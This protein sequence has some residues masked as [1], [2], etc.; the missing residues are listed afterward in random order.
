MHFDGPVRPRLALSRIT[1]NSEIANFVASREAEDSVNALG[2]A[3]AVGWKRYFLLQ[4]LIAGVFALLLA[5]AVV[6]WMR[7]SRR[8]TVVVLLAS[9]LCVE[10]VNVGAVMIGARTAQDRLR[11][12]DSLAAL[13]GRTPL[14]GVPPAAEPELGAVDA[15]VLGVSV[16]TGA[17][18]PAVA[19]PTAQ[20]R[21]CGRS[22]DA[23]A[24]K[25]AAVNRWRVVNLACGGATITAGVAGSQQLGDV[26]VP[27]QLAVAKKSERAQVVIVSIGANDVGWSSLLR[28]CA[29]TPSCDNNASTAYFQQQLAEFSLNYEQ[30]LLR[31]R[32]LPV[33]PQILINLYFD[34]FG[35]SQDCLAEHGLTPAMQKSLLALLHSLNEVLRRGAEAAGATPVRPDFTGHGLCDPQPYVQDV[36]AAAPFHPTAAGQLAIAL[37][38]Q[39]ALQ[40]ELTVPPTTR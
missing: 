25:L 7:L 30:L 3:L 24:A 16:A 5:G 10:A 40:H 12:V 23:F 9:L 26:V 13:V 4:T 1:L 19:E 18:L 36:N 2:R 20:A 37:A 6:G 27:P 22:A 11:E 14:P 33:H 17:G 8:R 35:G 39:Q 31:L 29:V 21:A 32:A 15:L 34:P 38:D 28:L